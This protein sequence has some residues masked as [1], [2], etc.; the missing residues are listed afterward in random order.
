MPGVRDFK[1]ERSG[2]KVVEARGDEREPH[3]HMAC[4]TKILTKPRESSFTKK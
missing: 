2:L 3:G 1:S 4:M